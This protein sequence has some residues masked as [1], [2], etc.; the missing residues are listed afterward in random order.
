MKNNLTTFWFMIQIDAKFV[1]R[2]YI[3]ENLLLKLI[4]A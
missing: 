4:I 2:I 1:I 3:F